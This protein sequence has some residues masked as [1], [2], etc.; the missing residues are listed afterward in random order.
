MCII[1]YRPANTIIPFADFESCVLNNPDGY[2][3]SVPKG[4][5]SSLLTL[6]SKEAADPENLYRL[7]QEEFEEVPLMLHLRYNTAGDTNLRNAHPFPILEKKTHG[8]DLRM[9]HNGTITKWRD[10]AGRSKWES[11]TRFFT[12]GFVRPLFERMTRSDWAS[13]VL[14]D[15]WVKG[16]IQDQ[17][18]KTSVLTFIDADG[19]FHGINEEGNGGFWRGGVYYSNKYSLRANH[20]TTK[21]YT[22]GYPSGGTSTKMTGKD[23]SS[24]YDSLFEEDDSKANVS[25]DG[26]LLIEGDRVIT[27]SGLTGVVQK[28]LEGWAN[29]KLEKSGG[30]CN[31]Q[32]RMLGLLSGGDGPT[33]WEAAIDEL[34]SEKVCDCTNSELNEMRRA[35]PEALVA[36]LV[37]IIVEMEYNKKLETMSSNPGGSTKGTHLALVN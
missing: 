30:V 15:N 2:G 31:Y 20:R 5:G 12:R 18:P 21:T 34:D 11:D 28:V 4:D 33:D 9:A 27:T 1:I 14:K 24:W 25:K 7:I 3:F 19:V 32:T 36:K 17:I 29:V 8:E 22:V 6:R 35:N 13:D 37:D 10:A 26:V 23:Y 16:L